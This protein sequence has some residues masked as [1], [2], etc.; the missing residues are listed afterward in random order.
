M[1]ARRAEIVGSQ[2]MLC[3]DTQSKSRLID[4]G[5]TIMLFRTGARRRHLALQKSAE[6]LLQV[7]Y[8]IALYGVT[9]TKSDDTALNGTRVQAAC[10]SA[11]YQR[12]N[13]ATRSLQP[14]AEP[15]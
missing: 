10:T 8:S 3:R 1:F 15:T 13:R 2:S 7:Q 14:A 11:M 12:M 9:A 6:S 5:C 4:A